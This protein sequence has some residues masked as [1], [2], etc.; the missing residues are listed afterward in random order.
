MPHSVNIVLSPTIAA[1]LIIYILTAA[2]AIIGNAIY[3]FSYTVVAD[4]TTIYFTLWLWTSVPNSGSMA[5][6]SWSWLSDYSSKICSYNWG[7]IQGGQAWAI[8]TAI[9]ACVALLVCVFTLILQQQLT[10]AKGA[11]I[12]MAMSGLIFV[13]SWIAFALMIAVVHKECNGITVAGLPSYQLGP[14]AF[15]Y[16]GTA[17]LSAVTLVCHFLTLK[18]TKIARPEPTQAAVAAREQSPAVV[19]SYGYAAQ[20]PVPV[21]ATDTS[22]TRVVVQQNHSP[23][24]HELPLPEGNDWT[25]DES[26]LYWSDTKKL[27]FDRA[28]GQFYDPSSD[29]WF[30]PEQNI[31]YK[32]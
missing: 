18:A 26:G 7:L 11:T 10:I 13:S 23:I 14:A 12:G 3:L 20:T 30:N 17:F 27:F 1:P 25:L 8:I 24:R 28:S 31:W 19:R 4:N 22:G 21:P 5:A 9:L 32:L 6:R 2:L 16:L 15:M 29:K